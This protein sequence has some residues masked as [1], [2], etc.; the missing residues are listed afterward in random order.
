MEN[1]SIS[2]EQWDHLQMYLRNMQIIK[3]RL[4]ALH[5]L[6]DRGLPD[7]FS[8]YNC[9]E[10]C[11]LQIRK[12]LELIA[13][14]SL[15]SDADIYE[16]Q[17]QNL[18]KKWN[19]RLILNDIE[20]I[21]PQFYPHP[22]NIEQGEPIRWLEK[23]EGFLSREEFETIYDKCGK[24]LHEA[25]SFKPDADIEYE[26]DQVRKML[27]DWVTLIEELLLVHYVW[28]YNE[29]VFLITLGEQNEPPRG[30]ILRKESKVKN[31]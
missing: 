20:R 13:F 26:Y 2:S 7:P 11:V 14:S 5:A 10:F 23:E 24:F 19:A 18:K 1:T 15:A 31:G 9:I 8:L 4:K 25:S 30:I 27:P 6:L 3:Y 12:I 21:H 28:L 16:K 29:D 17:L 22:I